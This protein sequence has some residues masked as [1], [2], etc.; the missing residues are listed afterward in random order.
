[1]K[2]TFFDKFLFSYSDSFSGH[3]DQNWFPGNLVSTHCCCCFQT[4]K[5]NLDKIWSLHLRNNIVSDQQDMCDLQIHCFLHV[6]VQIYSLNV[7]LPDPDPGLFTILSSMS[8]R[9]TRSSVGAPPLENPS[10]QLLNWSMQQHWVVPGWKLLLNPLWWVLS[11][12][13]CKIRMFGW[14]L[15]LSCASLR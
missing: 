11:W 9:P 10:K 6:Q 7:S 5:M 14:V 3:I 12:I 4:L 1:M 2:L 13:S 15:G 8:P